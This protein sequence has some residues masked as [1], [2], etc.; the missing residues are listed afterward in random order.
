MKSRPTSRS[1]SLPS[2]RPGPIG[3]PE[4][5]ADGFSSRLPPLRLALLLILGIAALSAL[6][7]VSSD[8]WLAGSFRAASA[9]LLALWLL[10]RGRL[11]RGR[12]TA[13][14]EV[15]P[16]PVHYVQAAMQACIYAY[17][18]WYWPAVYDHLPLVAAQILFAYAL[19][20]LVCWLR[21]DRWILGFG[22]F[23]IILSTNLFLWFRD[24]WFFLQFLMVATGVLGK[25]LVQWERDGRRTHVFNPSALSLFVFS[26]GLLVTGRTHITWGPEIAASLNLPPQIYLEIFLVG[27]VVQALFSVTLVTLAAAASLYALNLVYTELTGTYHFLIT[28]IPIAV[29]LGLHLLVTDPATSPRTGLGRILFGGLYGLAT[30]ALFGVLGAFDLPTFYDKLLCVPALNLTVRGLDRLA[31]WARGL[32]P[33]RFGSSWSPARLNLAAISVWTALFLLMTGTGFF[34]RAHPG[35]DPGFWQRACEEGRPNGCRAWFK[36]LELSCGR[37]VQACR[38]LADAQNEGR[39]G[40]RRPLLAAKGYARACDRGD[41]EACRGLEALARADGEEAFEPACR[42]GDT[43]ACFI[44]GEIRFNGLGLPQDH[45]AALALFERACENGLTRGCARL[46][47]AY[48]LGEGTSPDPLKALASFEEACRGGHAGSCKTAGAMHRRGA[49]GAANEAMAVRWLRRA[50]EL[51]TRDACLPGEEPAAAGL[52]TESEIEL[53]KLGG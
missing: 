8:P 22:Q 50:C 4:S 44:L 12:R 48:L 24:E 17:W 52:P 29:F 10:V 27:L 53:L 49:A 18:G 37:D 46:G 11:R 34:D 26:I 38:T 28:N 3:R 30:F 31:A 21:R 45:A 47:L 14:Y 6:P 36:L 23:P 2:R 39:F 25:Q 13:G 35:R 5:T 20:M 41:G 42:T 43:D 40:P 7:R 19:D 15:V 1:R 51:G 9:A 33:A 32:A 16:L